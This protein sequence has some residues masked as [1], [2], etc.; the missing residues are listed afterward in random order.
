[1]LVKLLRDSRITHKA[2]ETVEVS[3]EA[4]RFL[5]S[6]GSAVRTAVDINEM[7]ETADK[8]IKKTRKKTEK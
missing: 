7:I 5:I 6:V 2:G 3:P 1:M 4:V 8:V